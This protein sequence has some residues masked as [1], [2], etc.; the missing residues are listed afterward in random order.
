MLM[1]YPGGL[2]FAFGETTVSPA[3]RE[4]VHQG[5]PVD[6]GN[7]AF[8]LLVLLLEQRGAVVS[9]DQIMTVVW[10]GRVVS[11][12]TLEGQMS[13]L[14]RALGED[15]NAI[16]TIAG[17][18]YQFVGALQREC[19]IASVAAEEVSPG[20]SRARSVRLP[21]QVS[22]LI[23]RETEL[24]EVSDLLRTRRLVTLVGTAG[25]GKT[26]LAIEAARAVSECFEDGVFVAELAATASGDCVLPAIAA[27]LGFPPGNGTKSL[28]TTLTGL[29]ERRFLLVID[30]CEHVVDSAAC[31][32]EALLQAAPGA[33]V[34]ATSREAL[35]IAGEYVYRVPALD[36][37]NDE[38][39]EDACRFG[40]IMLLRERLG[41]GVCAT[42]D[43]TAACAMARIC[44]RLDGMP[45]AIELAA[46]CVPAFG[47]EG[48]A[49]LLDDRF[50]LLRHGARTALPRQQT[51]RAAVDWSYEPL[52]EDWKTVLKRLG[53]FTDAFTLESAQ[54]MISSA[55]LS[56][57]AVT[58]A[59]AGLVNKSLLCAIPGSPHMRYRLLETI[60]VYARERLQESGMYGEWAAHHAQCFLHTFLVAERRA[61][62]RSELNQDEKS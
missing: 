49:E 60:R 4:L 56:P 30:N 10:A 5:K 9:K 14:R 45:L 42:D 40:A 2:E 34:L 53:L 11:E 17:R 22:P 8:E 20:D 48:V 7:R 51:L 46:A 13:T 52:P 38:D 37:P 25:V 32:V 62:T 6:V 44:R 50:Q 43:R 39:E 35:R 1:Q 29:R 41:P 27:A 54:Q 61:A 36:I 31:I 58:A 33:T 12:N 47:L 24:T 3:R 57:Q 28:E 21:A 23:G 18:G 55:E 19:P 16:K 26:R 59:I 15:R